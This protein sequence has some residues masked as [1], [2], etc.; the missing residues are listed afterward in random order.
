MII[1][2]IPKLEYENY[3]DILDILTEFPYHLSNQYYRP[4]LKIGIFCFT[5]LQFIPD[6]LKKYIIPVRIL[7]F[8]E[9]YKFSEKVLA[10]LNQKKKPKQ[11]KSTKKKI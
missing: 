7:D 9:R 10:G 4:K 1:I 3:S 2:K 5:K 11:R 6:S 8:T